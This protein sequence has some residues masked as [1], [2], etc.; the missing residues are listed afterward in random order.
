M[1]Q[2]DIKYWL[3][4]CFL[5]ENNGLQS[6]HCTYT[7][8]CRENCAAIEISVPEGGFLLNSRLNTAKTRQ[9]Q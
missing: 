8:L 5:F 7:I 4:I 2:Q 6:T 9:N 1:Y 3:I